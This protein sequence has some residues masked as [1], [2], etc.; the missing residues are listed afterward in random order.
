MCGFVYIN[1]LELGDYKGTFPN[2]LT[3]LTKIT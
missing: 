3:V 2:Y 1:V